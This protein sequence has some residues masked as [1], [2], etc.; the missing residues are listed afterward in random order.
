V[1]LELDPKRSV[2]MVTGK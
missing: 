2:R 1:K